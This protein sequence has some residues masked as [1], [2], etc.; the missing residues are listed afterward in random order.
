METFKIVDSKYFME[1][2]GVGG[3]GCKLGRGDRWGGGFG[4]GI[5][6]CHRFYETF[7]HT[8]CS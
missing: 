1:G 2:A 5:C 4:E 7:L 3:L 8:S 6:H